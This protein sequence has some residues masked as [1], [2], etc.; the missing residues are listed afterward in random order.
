MAPDTQKARVNPMAATWTTAGQVRKLF[1]SGPPRRKDLLLDLKES[2]LEGLLLLHRLQK[3]M[4]KAGLPESD[5]QAALVLMND[6]EGAG[7]IYLLPIPE[8]KQLPELYGKLKKLEKDGHWSPLGIAIKQLDRD[9][10]APNEAVAWV[11]P[12]L[13]SPRA[14]RALIKARS[15]MAEGQEGK[16]TFN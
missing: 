3:A 12:W 15:V 8:T 2:L 14:A 7:L 4:S 5:V 1:K 6:A 9:P 11:H 13:T 16:S 10:K